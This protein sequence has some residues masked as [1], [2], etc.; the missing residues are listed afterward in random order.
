M[1]D[2]EEDEGEGERER[3]GG[4]T[5]D[6]DGDDDVD[7]EKKETSAKRFNR[8]FSFGKLHQRPTTIHLYNEVQ[9]NFCMFFFATLVW[10]GCLLLFS[11]LLLF[12]FKL[13]LF[14]FLPL[15]FLHQNN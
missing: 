10:F 6:N 13:K 8:A 9:G 15:L 2:K 7:G 1:E 4:G 5:G 14:K 3:V 11:L 12:L